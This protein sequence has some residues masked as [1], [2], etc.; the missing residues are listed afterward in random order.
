MAV[1]YPNA[2]ED[3]SITDKFKSISNQEKL[4][5]SADFAKGSKIDILI[6]CYGKIV[7]EALKAKEI[8]KSS[9]INCGIILLELIKPYPEIARTVCEYLSED[10]PSIIFL[11]EEI[12]SGGMGMNLKEA[13]LNTNK[14]KAFDS[15]IIATDDSFIIDRLPGEHIYDSAKISAKYIVKNAQKLCDK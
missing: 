14:D 7:S 2:C 3:K 6:I 13:L 15:V 9:G 8:L 10:L 12:K 1:R 11:E 5:A 4:S